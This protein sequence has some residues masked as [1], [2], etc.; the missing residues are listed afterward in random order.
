M[1]HPAL[2]TS[3]AHPKGKTL[4][5]LLLERGSREPDVLAQ[6]RKW[7]GIW[8]RISWGDILMQ[9][10][11]ISAGLVAKGLQRG[12][13]VAVI[14]ENEPEHL[15]AELAIQA[16]GGA[17]VSL[18]PDMTVEEMEFILGHCEAVAVFA[19]DQE[20]TDKV[21][22][23]LDRLSRINVVVYWD[24]KGMWSYR[25]PLLIDLDALRAHGRAHLS[26]HPRAFEAAVAQG[27]PAD[28][29]IVLYTSGTTGKPKGVVCSHA[30]LLDNALRLQTAAQIKPGAEYLSYIPLAW[31]TEQ[32]LGVALG[33]VG[34]MV[35]NFPERPE[36]ILAD[37]REIG[38]EVVFFGS[39]QWESLA[40][41]VRAHMFDAGPIRRAIHDYGLKVGAAER[42][43]RLEGRRPSVWSRFLYPLA[44]GIVLKP[45]RDKL[46]LVRAKAALCAGSAMAPDAFR[47]FHA[48][49]I[50]LR[51][52]YGATEFGIVSMHQGAAFDLETTG[53]PVPVDASF[54]DPIRWRLADDGEL[55]VSGGTGF[56]RYLK[57]DDK[58][59]EKRS[60]SWF[61]TGDYCSLAD[62]GDLVFLERLD[63][64]RTL[65][66]GDR[67]PPQ[68]IETRLRFSP[69]IREAMTVGDQEREHVAALIEI[70][71]DVVAR[72]AEQRKIA[73]STLG[74]LSQRQEIRGLICAE[75]R[76]V[77]R[78][79]PPASRVRTFANLPK[80]LDP[81]E[82]E[83]TRTRK[84]RR[85]FLSE[86]YADLIEA[87]Y[88]N[89]P[90]VQLEVP[91]R[92][93][94]GKRGL[95]KGTVFIEAVDE[96]SV[97]AA[98]RNR[99]ARHPV[100]AEAR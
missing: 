83:L 80:A 52:A 67:Y 16:Y 26:E 47:L 72:W 4:P 88:G 69:F 51:S 41:S 85:S 36:S 23:V 22:A 66:G 27:S 29:A 37:L 53:R 61:R 60:A 81:D 82:G 87:L 12:E 76:H 8:H 9:V 78:L 93:Q 71:G 2:S 75:I 79:L 98:P 14:G 10:R 39:R 49:G 86:R 43:A 34:P 32:F 25:H 54:G 3:L 35:V 44:N 11:E 19:Q 20:Q 84:L 13:T 62:N 50:P 58:T 91:I 31:S 74:D 7:R 68:Y 30:F 5:Q 100:P 28:T 42:I 92:Y 90:S 95:L 89:A 17:C 24:A 21:L 64:L 38:V 46:G 55:L 77:N 33:L 6:R 63:D 97:K 65:A 59:A 45:L 94:D 40:S 96:P 99:L 56:A 1:K 48:M 18:Y 70:D 15:A 57:Q 73:F